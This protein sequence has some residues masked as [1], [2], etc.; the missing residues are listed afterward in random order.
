[1]FGKLFGKRRSV[2][3]NSQRHDNM[4]AAVMAE[5]DRRKPSD[6]LIGAKI[7]AAEI[8]TRLTSAVKDERG[9]H[10]ETMLGAL[11][12]LAGFACAAS[13]VA[14][15]EKSGKALADMEVLT[16]TARDGSQYLY[17]DAINAPFLSDPYA[18]WGL[19]G[20]MAQH[21]GGHALPDAKELLAHVAASIGSS[22]FGVPRLPANHQPGISPVK[23]VHDLWPVFRQQREQF[24]DGPKQ[25]PVLFGLAAQRVMEMGR[26]QIDPDL[27][28]RVVLE[29]AA[30]MSKLDPRHARS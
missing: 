30:P 26:Q 18:V 3:P 2:D 24:C 17:G 15:S 29:C 1:M 4:T 7:G 10:I 13:V 12:A 5:I 22:T 23:A 11:G 16:V 14:L 25:W 28:A 9:V 27:A 8:V 20:G 21:L 19:V 6:P